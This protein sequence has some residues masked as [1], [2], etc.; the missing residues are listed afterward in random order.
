MR[1]VALLTA[2]CALVFGAVSVAYA[3]DVNQGL[4][5]K[6]TGKKGTKTK[7]TPIKL[8]VTTTT[9]AKDPALDGT[10]GT[11]KA[12]IHFD[13][14]LYFSA[15]DT[16][17]K[18][19]TC[20]EAVVNATPKETGCPKGSKVSIDTGSGAKAQ[21][22]TGATAIKAN[23]AIRAYNGGGGKLI[24]K[25]V[26]P[27]GEFDATGTIVAKLSKDTGKYGYKLTVPIPKK[28]YDQFGIKITLQKFSTIVSATY[29][30]TGYVVSKGCTGTK[31]NF[32]GDFTFTDGTKAS[33]KTTS[34][35]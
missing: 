11:T 13:K 29:K 22:G 31:Y 3:V 10:Y 20:T 24:L 35:C 19:P 21:G 4:A 18:W 34:K 17:L 33:V 27:P 2:L 6:T 15:L 5:I 12:V 30:K 8:S 14:N 1:K 9:N 28:Y 23:P 7:P 16:K 26:S 25:L 32:A